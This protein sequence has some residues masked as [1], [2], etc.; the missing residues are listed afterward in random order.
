MVLSAKYAI[1]NVNSNQFT[2]VLVYPQRFL[3]KTLSIFDLNIYYTISGLSI[4]LMTGKKKKS[5]IKEKN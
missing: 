5:E 4:I 3:F 1:S 2:T